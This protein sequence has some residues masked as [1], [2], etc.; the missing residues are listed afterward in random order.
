MATLRKRVGILTLALGH[1]RSDS[2][3]PSTFIATPRRP[4]DLIKVAMAM[5]L[6]LQ[7]T[8]SNIKN[9]AMPPNNFGDS[10]APTD[11]E[12]ATDVPKHTP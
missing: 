7:G 2:Y 1:Q 5:G 6:S 4:H 9:K 3:H 10:K 8:H 12:G 11:Y